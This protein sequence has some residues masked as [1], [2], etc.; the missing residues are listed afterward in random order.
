MA[1]ADGEKAP[2]LGR[3]VLGTLILLFGAFVGYRTV[4][5]DFEARR[6]GAALDQNGVRVTGIVLDHSSGGRMESQRPTVKFLVEGRIYEVRAQ[7]GYGI[8]EALSRARP[9]VSVPRTVRV[10]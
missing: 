10:R 9:A 1:K 6:N 2:G 5:S 4:S 8:K 7:N 3:S